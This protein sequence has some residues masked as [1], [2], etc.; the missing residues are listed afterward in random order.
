MSRGVIHI[1]MSVIFVVIAPLLLV[2][3]I[4]AHD[5]YARAHVAVS[6]GLTGSTNP[7]TWPVSLA[8]PEDFFRKAQ[9]SAIGACALA[10]I[11]L[12][13]AIKTRHAAWFVCFVTCG[14]IAAIVVLRTGVRY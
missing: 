8:S 2:R 12:V 13:F 14:S 7:S 3:A 10:V 1:C 11:A 9:W 4:D 6:R 5:D